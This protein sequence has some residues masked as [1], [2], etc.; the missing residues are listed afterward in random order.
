MAALD[1]V[2]LAEWADKLAAIPG[3]LDNARRQAAMLLEPKSIALALPKR[4]ITSAAELDQFLADIR[5]LI[6][7]RLGEGPITQD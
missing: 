3:R 5:A 1:Q 7:P 6:E 4:T 2:P